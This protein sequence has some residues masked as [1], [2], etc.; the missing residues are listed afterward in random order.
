MPIGQTRVVRMVT[1]E[2]PSRN[3]ISYHCNYA[4]LYLLTQSLIGITTSI[5]IQFCVQ[6]KLNQ[7]EGTFIM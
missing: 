4:C 3:S 6:G 1:V 5:F 2:H 7:A